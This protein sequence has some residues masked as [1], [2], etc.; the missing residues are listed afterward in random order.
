MQLSHR[1]ATGH[2]TENPSELGGILGTCKVWE[3]VGDQVMYFCVCVFVSFF[4][5]CLECGVHNGKHCFSSLQSAIAWGSLSHNIYLRCDNTVHW[6]S[7]CIRI[8][9]A[10]E[11]T[12]H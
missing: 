4:R 1:N 8:H 9:S 3:R 11:F 6:N 2:Y 12:M 7:Q 10:L 5:W